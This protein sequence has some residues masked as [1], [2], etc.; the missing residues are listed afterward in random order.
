MAL[1]MVKGRESTGA[2]WVNKDFGF[3]AGIKEKRKPFTFQ[4]SQVCGMKRLSLLCYT[5]TTVSSLV[6]RLQWAALR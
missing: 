2:V 4:N 1:W 6:R 5:G 3:I